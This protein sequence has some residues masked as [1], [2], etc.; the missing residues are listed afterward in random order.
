MTRFACAV[1]SGAEREP[2]AA[3]SSIKQRPAADFG[4]VMIE[5]SEL[6]EY[7][8]PIFRGLAIF[9]NLFLLN[10]EFEIY[11]SLTHG[12]FRR[13]N[14]FSKKQGSKNR[15]RAYCSRPYR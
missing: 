14:L 15:S 2:Q 9:N 1:L 8:W 12:K 7:K 3:S 4:A 13:N 5:H 6:Y 11:V 10:K